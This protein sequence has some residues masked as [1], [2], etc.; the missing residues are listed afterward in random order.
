[1]KH[2]AS[3]SVFGVAL[4]AL[5]ACGRE[6]PASAHA[7]TVVDSAVPREVALERFRAGLPAPPP[8]S[9]SGGARSRE[10]L[11]RAFV[12]AVERADTAALRTLT[13]TRAEFAWLYYPTN[14]QGLP[15]YDLAPGLMWELLTLRGGRGLYHLLEQR[16][17]RPLGYLGHSCDER[18]SVEGDNRVYGPCL[19]RRRDGGT[20]V[21]ERLFGLVLERGGRFKFVSLANRLD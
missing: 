20:V 12:R 19:V 1:V 7:E 2:A 4:L 13:L 14:P 6:R 10:A 3:L 21:E 5:A 15:P 11:V 8:E 17:G 18:V 16:A 9:L